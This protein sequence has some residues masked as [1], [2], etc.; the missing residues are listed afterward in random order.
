MS[1]LA[2]LPLPGYTPF[3]IHLEIAWGALLW[4]SFTEKA[5]ILYHRTEIVYQVLNL[6]EPG[7]N[8]EQHQFKIYFMFCTGQKLQ[9]ILEMKQN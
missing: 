7:F 8:K 1:R 6:G 9:A 5:S 3:L 4:Q 2:I